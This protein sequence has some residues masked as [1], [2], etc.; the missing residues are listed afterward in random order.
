MDDK[1]G[2]DRIDVSFFWCCFFFTC[3]ALQLQMLQML[4]PQKAV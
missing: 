2:S 4:F 1:E 3:Q